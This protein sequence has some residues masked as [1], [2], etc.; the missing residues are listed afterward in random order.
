MAESLIC[1]PDE[2]VQYLQEPRLVQLTTLDAAGGPF[3]NVIS[4]VLASTPDALRLVGDTRTQFMQNLQRDAKTA[5]TVYGAGSAWTVYGEARLLG[6]G[7]PG[8]PPTFAL[9][10]VTGLRV[11]QVLFFG[12]VLT[13][14]PQWDVTYSRAEADRF[15]QAVF[16]AMRTAALSRTPV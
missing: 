7:L 10:E 3:V 2:L 5:L 9:V 15:D 14:A 1:M 12:A 13:Q 8:L 6:A 11:H 16:A 4:W